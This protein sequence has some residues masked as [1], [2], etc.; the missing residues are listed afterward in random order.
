VDIA[1]LVERLAES[2]V[3]IDV[4]DL[5]ALADV[6]TLF[7]EAGD[8]A[9]DSGHPEIA[10]AAH[11]AASL[12]E[13]IILQDVS[14][15][16]EAVERLGLAVTA[17]QEVVRDG[18]DPKTVKWPTL[19]ACDPGSGSAGGPS[20]SRVVSSQMD[21]AILAEFLVR[22]SC[23]LEEFEG[24]VLSLEES[25]S[26]SALGE[27]RRLIHT[28]KGESAMLGFGEIERLCHGVEDALNNDPAARLTDS[29]LGVK[30]WLNGCFEAYAQG[31]KAPGLPEELTS[32]FFGKTLDEGS[33]AQPIEAGEP[34]DTVEESVPLEGDPELLRE[35]IQEA[36]EHLEAADVHLLT[37][38]TDCHDHEAINAVFRAFHTIKGVAGF[39]AL[40]QVQSLAHEAENLLDRVRKEEIVL[41]DAAMDITFDAVDMLK[42]LIG[43]VSMALSTGELSSVPSLSTLVRK[44]KLIAS[45]QYAAPLTK[46]T[47]A[48]MTGQRLGDILVASGAATS[49]AVERAIS[50]QQVEKVSKKLGDILVD[51]GKVRDEIVQT[52]LD[53]QKSDP[54]LGKTGEIL[55]EMD[56]VSPDDISQALQAQ[57][58]SER[59]PML[60]ELLVREHDAAARDVGLALRGQKQA[61]QQ[62]QAVAV[63]EAVKVDA[64]RLDLLVDTIGELVIAE[65]MVIQSPELQ[66]NASPELSRHLA[67]LDKITRELQEMGM[68]LRMVPL[69]STFQKMARL[70]RDVAKKAG[71]SVDFVMMGEDT[72]LDKTVVD[73]ISDP[74]VHMIRNAVDHGLEPD[75]ATRLKA[76]KR[77]DGRVELRA[78]HRGGSIY[79]EI[80]DDGHGLDRDAIMAKARDR[81]LVKDGDV[82]SDRDTWN[83]IF[84]PGFSTA[85]K[86]TD[87]SGRG[88]GMDVVKKNIEALRGQIEIQT[89]KGKGTVFSMRLPLT[90]A[91]IDGMVVRVGQERYILP[92]LSILTSLRPQRSDLSSVVG[93]SEMLSLQGSLFPLFRLSRLFRMP[94]ALEDPTEGTVIIVEDEGKKTGLLVDE[95]LG[96]Q[97]IVIKSLGEMFKGIAGVA[98]GAIMPDGKVGL[99]LDVGGLVKLA[100]EDGDVRAA[101]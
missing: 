74:L 11:D 63:R 25:F 85:K 89:E 48:D 16:A 68:S 82:L 75:S 64:A 55:V 62:Q 65:S 59:T 47:T 49:E 21:E 20:S 56:A 32:V 88:V 43:N 67:Q 23:V 42:Q 58:D 76:G 40:G 87:V 73:K 8:G 100:T 18:R 29:L 35:F 37:L 57:R 38:E 70:V 51:D 34:E 72:E 78:F 4:A 24:L 94:G 53:I 17:M 1:G 80:A 10:R 36:T 12:V 96:Q 2:L 84:V 90:L 60:G 92:T 31:A 71:K 54:H 28:L 5:R 3:L 99:I 9:Q 98:G 69:R 39:L 91:I 27:L 14:D 7:T 77:A 79:I 101:V 95:I 44:I 15:P 30:D 97:Q 46:E 61:Q 22:Q 83:L 93:R 66:R 26:E 86:V 50:R 6:H 45:G 41:A 81:G 33:D 19:T 13:S 52:A